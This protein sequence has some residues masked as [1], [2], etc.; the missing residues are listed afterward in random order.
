[1]TTTSNK[2]PTHVHPR[3]NT[4]ESSP[5]PSEPAKAFELTDEQASAVRKLTYRACVCKHY[6]EGKFGNKQQL[7]FYGGAGSGKTVATAHRNG[8]YQTLRKDGLSVGLATTTHIAAGVLRANLKSYGIDQEVITLAAALGLREKRRGGEV[9]FEPK[10][11]K[12]CFGDFDVWL[13]DESS[14]I[15]AQ[16]MKFIA[17]QQKIGQTVIF[18]GD[19]AQLPPVEG[20][21]DG[22]TL[23]PAMQLKE[24]NVARL[25]EIQRYGGVLLEKATDI[26]IDPAGYRTPWIAASDERGQITTVSARRRD[27]CTAFTE[28]LELDPG[29]DFRMLAYSN[30]SVDTWNNVAHLQ[31]YGVDADPFHVG[32]T[33]LTREA[34]KAP[35]S[36]QL[37]PDETPTIMWGASS[38][39]EI[40]S[41]GSMEFEDLPVKGVCKGLN[42]WTLEAFSKRTNKEEMLHVLDN[43]SVGHYKQVINWYANYARET[44]DWA[45]FWE[46]K[47]AFHDVQFGWASTVHRAQ[48][49]GFDTVFLDLRSLHGSKDAQLCRALIY[50]AATRARREIVCESSAGDS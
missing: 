1:M 43:S 39:V 9:T 22:F 23:S 48:G 20:Q 28:R 33:L 11:G 16:V 32:Q 3:R 24:E 26:R 7:G 47:D 25:T 44:G 30:N 35:G 15:P 4:P 19:E 42:Y 40:T 17:K 41:V 31:V 6:P 34:I 14:M 5:P 45:A 38:P 29:G 13:I 8:L 49:C 2:V 12:G 37:G 50:T 36:W 27:L 21:K 46:V 18:I 10:R